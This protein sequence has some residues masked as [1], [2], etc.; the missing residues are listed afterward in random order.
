MG[1]EYKLSCSYAFSTIA[2]ESARDMTNY[3]DDP[4]NDEKWPYA[5]MSY[6]GTPPKDGYTTFWSF[7]GVTNRAKLQ[8]KCRGKVLTEDLNE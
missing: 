7:Y 5:M 3:L 6:S 1:A 4:Y 8:T 2:Y